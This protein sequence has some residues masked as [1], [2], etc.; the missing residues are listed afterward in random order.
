MSI[1]EHGAENL[2]IVFGGG[3]VAPLRF[4]WRLPDSQLQKVV[5]IMLPS[6]SVN[7]SELIDRRPS[8]RS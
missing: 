4:A 6:S 8:G 3:R 5:E 7:I 2:V 1:L